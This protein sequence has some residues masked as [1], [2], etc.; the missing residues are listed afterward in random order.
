MT[1]AYIRSLGKNKK[2]REPEKPVFHPVDKGLIVL[3]MP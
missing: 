1:R 2:L 3:Y